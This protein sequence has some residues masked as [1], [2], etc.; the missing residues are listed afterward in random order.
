M[1]GDN[2]AH[3]I[4]FLQVIQQLTLIKIAGGHGPLGTI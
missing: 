4:F 2:T 1:K 3:T